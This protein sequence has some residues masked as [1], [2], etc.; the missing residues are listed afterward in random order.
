M[1]HLGHDGH[2]GV[3]S[4]VG[5]KVADILVPGKYAL[6]GVSL[7]E[8]VDLPPDCA[9]QRNRSLDL[10]LPPGVDRIDFHLGLGL[11]L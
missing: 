11:N 8:V 9:G 2:R 4:S 10:L 7:N 6:L 1:G 5:Q 3:G